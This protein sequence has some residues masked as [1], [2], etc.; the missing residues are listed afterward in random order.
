MERA[1]IRVAAEPVSVPAARQFIVDGLHEWGEHDLLDDARLCVSELAANAALHAGGPF[2]DVSLQRLPDAVRLA[3]ADEGLGPIDDLLSQAR[4]NSHPAHAPDQEVTTGRGLYLVE[5]VS[6]AW[7]VVATERGTLVWA[8]I[9]SATE[10]EAP[11]PHV[12]VDPPKPDRSA[13]LPGGWRV[14]EL[15]DCPVELSLRQDQHL[16]E[17]IRELQLVDVN[18]ASPP[19]VDVMSRLL[20]PQAHA[21]HTGR[22]AALQA[23]SAGLDHLTIQMP[24]LPS[25]ADDVIALQVAV[26]EADQLCRAKELLTLAADPEVSL[27]R[28]WMTET[29]VA[30]VKRHA[31]P[32]SWAEWRAAH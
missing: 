1:S 19:V 6:K 16:D 9:T 18:G 10:L 13:P 30:Q 12:E 8:D 24:A 31:P 3:V 7:G 29:I 4:L 2:M 11:R 22:R 32:V 5:A 23:R 17:L 25:V 15:L 21:R 27:L 20:A 26:R 14:V 28:D